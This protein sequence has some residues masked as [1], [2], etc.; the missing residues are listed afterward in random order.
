MLPIAI[1][2]QNRNH[3]TAKFGFDLIHELHG[4]DNTNH[5]SRLDDLTF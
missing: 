1:F 5:L 2:G 4:F 3:L